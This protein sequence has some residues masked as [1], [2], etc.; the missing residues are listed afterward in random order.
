MSAGDA[1]LH[2]RVRGRV[3]GV[4][5]RASTQSTARDLGLTGWV[6]NLPDG[7]VEAVAEGPRDALERLLAWTHEGP[8]QARV[9]A[10]DPTWTEA[11]GE[12][13]DFSVRR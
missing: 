3:Q 1:R 10:V 13:A 5:F 9:D 11:T 8:A 2:L 4:F 12:F 6:R 7:D